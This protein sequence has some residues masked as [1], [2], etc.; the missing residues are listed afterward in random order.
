M[1]KRIFGFLVVVL[2]ALFFSL[3]TARIAISGAMPEA[4]DAVYRDIATNTASIKLIGHAGVFVGN[5]EVVHMQWPQIQKVQ[6]TNFYVDYWGSFYVGGPLAA[7][8]RAEEARKLFSKSAKYSFFSHKNF[9]AKKPSG[10]CDGLIE[11]CCEKAGNNIV[12]DYHWSALSPQMQWKSNAITKRYT[13][14]RGKTAYS[15]ALID[16][17]SWLEKLL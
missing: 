3:S 12:N 4:G 17:G 15:S 2:V 5:F 11:H 9:G 8:N 13:T 10:R 1:L 7:K 16:V 14:T 6:L